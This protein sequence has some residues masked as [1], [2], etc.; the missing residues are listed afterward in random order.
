MPVTGPASFPAYHD[1]GRSHARDRFRFM[2]APASRSVP[3]V[4]P[5][6][7]RLAASS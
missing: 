7:R 4:I 2:T 6:P 3:R 5:L 1:T